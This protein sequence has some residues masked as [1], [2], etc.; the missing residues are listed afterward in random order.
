MLYKLVDDVQWNESIDRAMPHAMC[1]QRRE[2]FNALT[3]VVRSEELKQI[4][5][6]WDA[7][8]R[9]VW[10]RDGFVMMRFTPRR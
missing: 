2:V 5:A 3:R 9:E 1:R 4:C 6:E 10:M 7:G 8:D